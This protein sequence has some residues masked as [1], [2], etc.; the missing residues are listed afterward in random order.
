[1]PTNLATLSLLEAA[2][3]QPADREAHVDDDVVPDL[4]LGQVGQ[5]GVLAN[6]AEIDLAHGQP[7]VV[8]DLHDLARD[9]ETH[10]FS[11]PRWTRPP[12]PNPL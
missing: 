11:P 10:A 7:A 6:A 1:M 3:V 2:L 4:D 12:R 9:P 8:A 5:A